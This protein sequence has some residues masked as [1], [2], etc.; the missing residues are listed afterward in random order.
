MAAPDTIRE[1]LDRDPFQPF[2]IVMSSGEAVTIRNPD[3]V[4]VMRSEV[5]VA[6]PNSD[7][8]SYIPLLHIARVD[9]LSNGHR[10]NGHARRKRPK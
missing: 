4:V 10:G 7:K 1:L 5:F 6:E 9:M 2:R 3:L 8:R